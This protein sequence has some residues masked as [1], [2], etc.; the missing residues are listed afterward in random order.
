MAEEALKRIHELFKDC[1]V[2]NCQLDEDEVNELEL[3]TLETLEPEEIYEN[4]KELLGSLIS[5]KKSI[6]NSEIKE[7]TQRLIIFEKL[8]QKL[9]SDIRNHISIEHQM[10]LD[11]ETYEF[12]I[13]ELQKMK[14]YQVKKIES[15]DK[16][17]VDKESEILHIKNKN[18]LELEIKLKSIEEKFK[19]E[20]CSAMEYYRKDSGSVGRM[21]KTTKNLVIGEMERKMEDI[22]MKDCQS[23]RG[24]KSR[25]PKVVKEGLTERG[26]RTKKG[27][28]SG[29]E[30][31]KTI[32]N[33]PKKEKKHESPYL[34]K[35][36]MHIRSASD[37]GLTQKHKLTI[38]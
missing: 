29:V 8:I 16:L 3:E 24:K 28:T 18:A 17:L 25:F 34:K 30:L 20:I 27:S 22:N 11:M 13:E 19:H 26:K 7:L 38:L 10:R 4:L 35:D 37:L 36:M 32:E 12:K 2:Q 5:F 21:Q 31:F 9:E 33:L 6:N 23:G 15:L 1:F 14:Q